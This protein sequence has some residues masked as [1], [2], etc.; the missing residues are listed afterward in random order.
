MFRML[1]ISSF[2]SGFLRL[3]DAFSSKHISGIEHILYRENNV[4]VTTYVQYW[5]PSKYLVIII[6]HYMYID[7]YGLYKQIRWSNVAH[8]NLH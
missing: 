5:K 1:L 7:L 4:G 3:L 2:E 6:F 8:E